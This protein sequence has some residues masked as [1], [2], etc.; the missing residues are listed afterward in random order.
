MRRFMIAM[1]AISALTAVTPARGRE[2]LRGADVSFEPQVTAG[3]GV[4]YHAG[5]EA[6][7]FVILHANGLNLIR[8]RLWHSPADG[9]N[10]LTETLSLAVRAKAAG[11]RVLLDFHFSDTWADP[12]H[13]TKPAAWTGL[14]TN[15]L[16]DSVRAYTQAVME[17]FAARDVIPVMVQLGNEI[18]SGLLWNNGRVGGTYDTPDQW[19][20]L[21][22]L[23]KAAIAGID[24]ARI[25][26]PRPEIMIHLDRGGD[27]TGTRWFFDKLI[28]HG[29]DFD[30]IGLSYYPWWHG[31]LADLEANLND[32]AMRYGKDLVLVETAYPW[33]LQ[34][35]DNTHNPVGEAE[36]LLDGFPATPAGQLKFLSA[37]TA[38]MQAVPDGRGRGVVWWAPESIAAPGFGSAWENVTLFDERGRVLPALDGFSEGET[39]R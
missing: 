36:Q 1:L 10:S 3:G 27:N 24:E 21:T 2:F 25:G 38:I 22:E 37:V 28:D 17:A 31:T 35:F 12:G 30:L 34:W 26:E 15:V 29:L 16:A 7:L 11:L 9:H 18:T 33:T 32:L 39:G 6:D 13:Q 8:L 4:F 14:T 20:N 23:L 5:E 19:R